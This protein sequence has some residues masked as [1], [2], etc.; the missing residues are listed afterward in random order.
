YRIFERAY[1]LNPTIPVYDA[2]GNFSSV[3]GNIYENPV[4]ILT[5]R[6]V[7]NE[8]HR[9]LGYFKTEVKFLKDFTASANISLEHNAVKG[10]TYKPSYAVMEGR[11][12]D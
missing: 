12:E 5:N 10:A 8:R 4:E 7:D 6:T 3:S 11:T 1:N 9:L 2:N